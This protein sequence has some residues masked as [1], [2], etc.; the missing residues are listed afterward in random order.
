MALKMITPQQ[1]LAA[2]LTVDGAGSGLDA[3]LL[4]GVSGAGYGGSLA[5]STKT[6]DYTLTTSDAIILADAGSGAFTLTLPAASGNTGLLFRILKIESSAN[7]V[8]VDANASETINGATTIT[9]E[10]QWDAVELVCDGTGWNVTGG[11][12]PGLR[13]VVGVPDV[14]AGV[15]DGVLRDPAASGQSGAWVGWFLDT[16]LTAG[17]ENAEA[18]TVW[19][20]Y[21]E[22]DFRGQVEILGRSAATGSTASASGR[23]EAFAS[24]PD[25]PT[26]EATASLRSRMSDGGDPT[27]DE[28][29]LSLSASDSA[30]GSGGGFYVE[31]RPGYGY[32]ILDSTDGTDFSEIVFDA[33][34]PGV[35]FIQIARSMTDPTAAGVDAVKLF[36]KNE[37]I[38]QIDDTG[39]IKDLTIG[40]A[41]ET[42]LDFGSTPVFSGVFAV[43]DAAALTTHKVIISPSYAA[44]T[45]KTADE[46][47]FDS[48]V[49]AG[50][51][52][53][54]GTVNIVAHAVPGPVVGNFKVNYILA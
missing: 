45:G 24:H 14:S 11:Q 1:I 28:A 23:I 22:G 12:D 52:A 46:N 18:R 19:S 6:A 30:D 49:L 2:L 4:D 3:D 37:R 47:E 21:P 8:T 42:E 38:H 5:V 15:F 44:A 51:V 31:S 25:Q 36:V 17:S 41:T 29:I 34:T 27:D 26:R 9:L 54:N 48:L 53:T 7:A 32:A 40:A 10:R 20:G 35:S 43:A 13:G 16:D 39:A 50:Y 33:S